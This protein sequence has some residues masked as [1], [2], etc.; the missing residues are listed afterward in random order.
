[1]YVHPTVRCLINSCYFPNNYATTHH[2]ACKL[3]IDANATFRQLL[4]NVWLFFYLVGLSLN[5]YL[6]A[7]FVSTGKCPSKLT[8]YLSIDPDVS[9]TYTYYV[10]GTCVCVCMHV[11]VSM[12]IPSWM[13]YPLFASHL[14]IIYMYAYWINGFWFLIRRCWISS[15]PRNTRII[16]L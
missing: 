5:R 10:M 12:R 14:F 15:S 4:C 9:C 11:C 2:A 3:A 1:M 7:H 6:Q 13:P 8:A 16:K